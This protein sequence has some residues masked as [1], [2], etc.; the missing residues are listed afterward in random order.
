MIKI[1]IV[2]DSETETAILKT[3]F[4]SEPDFE[5]IACA[6]NGK[7]AV[8]LTQLLKPDLITMDIQMPVMDGI[9]AIRMIMT[10][11]P[12]PIIVISSKLN[13]ESLNAAFQAMEAGALSVL[14][15]PVNVLMPEFNKEKQKIIDTLRNMAEIKVIKR[16]FYTNAKNKISSLMTPEVKSN[17]Y[18]IIAIGSSVGGPQALKTILAKLPH[19]FPV[20]VVVVQHMT[21]GYMQGFCKWL[22][23]FT[24]LKVQTAKNNEEL[25]KGN[26]YFAPDECHLEIHRY[27][28]QLVAKLIPGQPISGFYPSITALFLSIAKV[29]GKNSIGIILTGMGNDGAKGLLELKQT[30]AHT[31]IQDEK[32]SVVFG[33]AGVAL[34]I[35]AVDKVIDLNEIADYLMKIT[36][37]VSE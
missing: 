33:M 29:S 36:K 1:L 19:N 12:V 18:E 23:G 25:Q 10:Q 2:D 27:N 20:P 21:R 35:G 30:K 15:K 17:H 7:E 37:S 6:K 16:R 32:S 3:L 5:V 8:E 22:N 11:Y 13:D 34:S 31:L 26:I 9:E 14:D 28:Q 24:A 4:N